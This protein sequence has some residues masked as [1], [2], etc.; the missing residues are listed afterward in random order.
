[1]K[2]GS[3]QVFRYCSIFKVLGASASRLTT[4][5]F[6]HR[7]GFLSSSFLRSFWTFWTWIASNLSVSTGVFQRLLV[8][9]KGFLRRLQK[10]FFCLSAWRSSIIPHP[11][12]LVN[13]FW[14]V[15]SRNSEFASFRPFGGSDFRQT[16]ANRKAQLRRTCSRRCGGHSP[17]LLCL[18][19]LC[20]LLCFLMYLYDTGVLSVAY[21]S[22]GYY[23]PESIAQCQE[24]LVQILFWNLLL[25]FG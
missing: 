16:A 14:Q 7:S 24:G 21:N 1:M 5:L 6:Y 17:A 3:L 13:T 10:S 23:L 25:N 18:A 11:G 12:A 15:F 20:P 2:I 19:R 9:F 8:L 22:G 4:W